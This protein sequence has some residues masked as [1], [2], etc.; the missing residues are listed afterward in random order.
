M[1]GARI[2]QPMRARNPRPNK[3]E[4]K[5]FVQTLV[6][7]KKCAVLGL[8]IEVRP[9]SLCSSRLPSNSIGL[10]FVYESYRILNR[11]NDKHTYKKREFPGL[12]S[13]G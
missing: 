5:A 8:L 7:K 4:R 1:E 12:I 6:Q 13:I 3:N 9:R 2:L 10:E 11:V